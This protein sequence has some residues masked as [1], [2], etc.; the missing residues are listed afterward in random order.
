MLSKVKSSLSIKLSALLVG[1]IVLCAV[2]VGIASI[3]LYRSDSIAENAH[4]ALDI[5]HAAAALIDPD[6]FTEIM[7][8]LEKN[9]HWY[10]VKN[11]LD[12][13]AKRT[14]V[15]YLYVLDANYSDSMI[16]FAEGFNPTVND[17]AEIDF[18]ESEPIVIDGESIYADEMFDVLR[19]GVPRV[20]EIYESGEFGTMVSG[21]VPITTQDGAVIGVIGV[22]LSVN[23]VIRAT[24]GFGLRIALIILVFSLAFAILCAFIIRRSI[25][26][27]LSVLTS[28]ADQMADGDVDVDIDVD[29]ADEIGVLAASFAEMSAY[30]KLQVELLKQLSEG[31]LTMQVT[32]R[33]P[34]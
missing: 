30:T 31:D 7:R 10:T 25:G 20:S 28:A 11:S 15:N 21:F 2:T 19:D 3:T 1:M 24:I 29:R 16:Y 23:E 14:N 13:I 9:D 27:P 5:A 17:E 6:Q 4:R 22:D 34:K 26:K 12:G 8:T 18:G 32:P 33:G